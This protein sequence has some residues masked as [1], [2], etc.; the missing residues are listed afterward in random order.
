[1]EG[2][3]GEQIPVGAEAR[4]QTDRKICK[5][6]LMPPRLPGEQVGQVNL[7]ERHPHREQGIPYRKTGVGVGP[8]VEDQAVRAPRQ[9]LNRVYQGTFVIA[10]GKGEGAAQ[11][12]GFVADH[13]LDIGERMGSVQRRFALAEEVQIGTIENRDPQAQRLSPRSQSLN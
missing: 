5:Q 3:E 7:H 2:A 10:L 6:G 12:L 9:L 1:M 8:P 4:D 11:R 13:P